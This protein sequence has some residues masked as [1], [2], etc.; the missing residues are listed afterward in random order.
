[1]RSINTDLPDLENLTENQA[2]Y[3]SPLLEKNPSDRPTAL[4]AMQSAHGYI[5]FLLGHSKKPTPM[6]PPGRFR[7]IYKSKGF[8]ASIALVLLAISGSMLNSK[9]PEKAS[10]LGI[11][12]TTQ[13]SPNET[14][15]SQNAP[16]IKASSSR[17]C[18][19]EYDSNGSDILKLCL[20]S[21]NKG[22][23]SSIF[24]I[25]RYYFSNSNFKEAEK[26]FLKGA[27]K[28]DLNSTR[29]LIETYTELSNTK[30]RDRWTKICADT[31]Y[32]QTDS[33]PLK[34]IA[35][36]KMMQGFILSKAGATKE[37]ILYLSDAADYGNGDAATWL[38][39]HYRDIDDKLNALKWLNRA[40][41]LGSTQGINS[42]ISYA[43]DIG[44]TELTKKWLLVSANSGNQ[45]NMGILAWTYYSEK[46]NQSALKWATK[47]MS[48][49]DLLST[50]VLGAV[51]YDSG[52]KNEGKI[53][54]QKAADKGNINAI[55]KLGTIYRIDEKNYN[56]AAIWYKKLADRND[57]TGTA[58]YSALLFTLGQ[59]KE[60][61]ALND[62][63]LDL[64]NQA[65]RNG[66][67][68]AALMDKYM[69]DAKSLADG[70]CTKLY[71]SN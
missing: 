51:K 23:R 70:W 43:D 18:E 31:S 65:K 7:K 42:L 33:S 39:V 64:G 63:V 35:Y 26:W 2:R 13:A 47:G 27:L 66:T 45:V 71:K 55:R 54:L 28:N 68:D 48:F 14:K 22:D 41:E 62:V 46:D 40:A 50:Y 59:D 32:G 56:E 20:P 12:E 3:L 21:A 8:L 30:E 44:D 10:D 1:M 69:S 49:G 37:A 6:K 19:A 34:D 16:E 36:C 25:G 15:F 11:V 5:E 67:Y 29:Y 9:T 61:C 53:L 4:E 52:Q 24:Y 60:S 58:I 17:D 57:F 38:G